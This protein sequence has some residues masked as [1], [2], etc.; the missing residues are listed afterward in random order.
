MS[1]DAK[2]R[3]ASAAFI[4]L[5][6]LSLFWPS[7]IVSS[8]QL[9]WNET[10]PVDHLSFLGREAPSWDVLFWFIAGLFA[11][12]LVQS[13]E[14]TPERLREPWQRLRAMRPRFSRRLAL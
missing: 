13:G 10:L 8:N 11:L 5:L 3:Y 7:P 1:I 6:L 12:I 14:V 2:R 9:W 4:T